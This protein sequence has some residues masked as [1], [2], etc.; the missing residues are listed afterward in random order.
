MKLPDLCKILGCVWQAVAVNKAGDMAQICKRCRK[1]RTI[2]LGGK[3]I[4]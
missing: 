2:A 3:V 4:G 1:C